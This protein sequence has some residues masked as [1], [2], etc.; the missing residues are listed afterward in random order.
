M[1][2]DEQAKEGFSIRAQQEK[3]RDYV[4][5]KDWELYDLYIDEG[6]SGKNIAA[7][8]ALVKMIADVMQKNIQNVL[9][10]RV[11]RLTRS[12]KD[13]INLMEIFREN[14]CAFNSLTESIDTQTA[15]GR[16]FIKII[17][18]FAEFERENLIERVSVALEKK[19]REGYTLGSFGMVPYGYTRAPGNR[20]IAVNEEEAGVVRDIFD[21]YLNGNMSLT[22]ITKT[23]NLR[24]VKSGKDSFWCVSSVKYILSNPIYISKVR[25]SVADEARYFEASGRHEAI[26]DE[27]VFSEAQNRLSKMKKRGSKKRPREENYFCAVLHCGI[28]GLKMTTQGHYIPD[29]HG[30]VRYYGGYK[31]NGVLKHTCSSGRI[32]HGKVELAF[33][34]YLGKIND[35]SVTMETEP[36]VAKSAAEIKSGCETALSALLTKE[37][38]VM[39]LYLADGISFEEYAQMQAMIKADRNAYA[40]KIAGLESTRDTREIVLGKDDIIRNV[41]ANWELMTN[42]ERMQFLERNIQAVYV[43]SEAAA[44][45]GKRTLVTVKKVEFYED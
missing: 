30:A 17:G 31:C 41:Q 1:S 45:G 40:E 28:C 44:V 2:T 6:I 13:L 35:F 34:E 10:F 19:V 43:E 26:I 38:G 14:N 29:K 27:A 8:P 24:K 23:L 21:L 3:L 15:S 16:M 4:R 37:R 32:S 5:I 42:L 20:E 11:D 39:K 12:T 9:V 18:I 25:Y 7:R 33:R 36:T 22:G